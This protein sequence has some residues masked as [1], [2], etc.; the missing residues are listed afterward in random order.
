MMD[1][2]N[3]YLRSINVKLL[4]QIEGNSINNSNF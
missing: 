4:S 1:V 3:E 2:L